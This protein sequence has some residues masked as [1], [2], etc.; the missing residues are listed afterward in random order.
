MVDIFLRSIP[1]PQPSGAQ[2]PANGI[3]I[4]AVLRQRDRAVGQRLCAFRARW[5]ADFIGQMGLGLCQSGVGGRVGWIQSD[6]FLVSLYR[7]PKTCQCPLLVEVLA[8]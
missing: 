7:M 5:L 6:R 3:S 4:R 1:I 2:L 8:E